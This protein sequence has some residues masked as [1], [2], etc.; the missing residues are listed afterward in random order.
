[1]ATSK[2]SLRR[3]LLSKRQALSGQ[4]RSRL[5]RR[6]CTHLLRFLEDQDALRLAAFFPFGGE[7]DLMPAMEILHQAGRR[8][9]LPVINDQRLEFKRW[10]PATAM[11][12][13]RFGIPEPTNG[14][15]FDGLSLDIV[16]MPLVAFGPGGERLG[17]GGGF[18][19]RAFAA[20]IDQPGTGPQRVGVA[21]GFQETESLPIDVW[22]VPLDA[23]ITDHGSRTFIR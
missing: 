21:Y 22:D 17:M 9:H 23:L 7:P 13:N 19:D 15:P 6:I 16:F 18:Y 5:D 14:S 8:I 3:Q 4:Q 12:S 2:A 20:F 10:Q 1:M 11:R